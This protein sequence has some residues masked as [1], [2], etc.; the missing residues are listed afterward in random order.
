MFGDLLS[1]L[2]VNLAVLSLVVITICWHR[3]LSARA[4]FTKVQNPSDVGSVP[5]TF[6][7]VFPLLGSL[8][9][10]YLWSPK[11]FVLNP[12][13]FFQSLQPALVRVLHHK[14]YVVRGSENVKALFKASG[15]CTSIPF[16][17]FA[18]GYAFGLPAKALR[19]MQ[20]RV[21]SDWVCHEDLMSLVGN[22]AT[23]ATLNAL[24][25][26]YLLKLNPNFLQDYWEFDRNLQTYLQG[27]PWF[28]AP[29]AYAA[30]KR[31][32]N[33]TQIWQQHARD[34]FDESKMDA[35]GDDPFWGSSFFRERHRMFLEMD[36]FDRAAIASEDFGAIWAVRNSITA[37]SWM[38]FD[39]YRDPELLACV[40]AEIDTCIRE[41][42]NGVPEYDV[43]QLLRLPVL[44]AVYAETLRLR[45]H[46]YIIR[47]PDRV[48]INI[49]DWVI[50]RQKV[51]VTPTTV[52]HMDTQAWY[53]GLDN[54]YPVE[55]FWAGR[56]L[57]SSRE[58]TGG[59]YEA[60]R[61]STKNLEG[62]WIP[63]GGGPRQCPGR[64]FAKRQILLTTALMISLFDCEIQP[65]GINMQE[66]V[67]LMGFGGG[68]SHPAGKV[69]AKIR[70]KK[71][72]T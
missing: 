2:V 12:N 45:M 30:R 16:V 72:R 51:I 67:S 57:Q 61:F 14:F 63:Y 34:H 18:L 49:K 62:S 70:R 1:P 52:A 40:R 60:P 24:C 13:N 64:H 22:E 59:S 4:Q 44:Q 38:I 43:D 9:L 20:D 65:E 66:D 21:G 29:R 11:E 19:F 71:T 39:I 56:F 31:A 27:M 54:E 58:A 3:Y 55:K 23:V 17:K 53:T 33:A 69:P 68:V 7:H 50:P 48:D 15:A 25:G 41:C 10:D 47:M 6:P 26:P 37:V 46:F 8:P 5:P 32:L 36:G 35:N 42:T 28:L